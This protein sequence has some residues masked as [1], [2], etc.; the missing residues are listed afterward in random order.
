LPS[1]EAKAYLPLAALISTVPLSETIKVSGC[2]ANVFRVSRSSFA[3][4]AI[5]PE[6]FESTSN[7]ALMVVS[8]SEA[9]SFKLDSFKSNKI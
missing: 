2:S 5:T 1:A 6:S 3:G 7:S 4:N 8:K 9:I